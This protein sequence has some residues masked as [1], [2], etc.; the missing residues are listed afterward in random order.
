MPTRSN[1]KPRKTPRQERAKET[2]RAILDAAAQVFQ[3]HGYA[4][5]TTDRIAERAGV[6]IGSLYQYFP[7]K[8][9]ILVALAQR[10]ID[11]GFDRVR[12]VLTETMRDQPNP[13]QLLRRFVEAMTALH[14][15]EPRLHRVLFEE[16]PLPASLRSELKQREHAFA[17]EVQALLETLPGIALRDPGLSAYLLVQCVE[18]LMHDFILHPPDNI[19]PDAFTDEIVYML[20]QYLKND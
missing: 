20:R 13:E 5:G 15:H 19:G 18:G 8:D 4:A 7:N 10:H 12:T 17:G 2:V 14:A 16:A 1:H 6:S 3:R 9:A 11:E